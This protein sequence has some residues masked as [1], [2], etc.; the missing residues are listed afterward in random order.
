[1]ALQ[2]LATS[3]SLELSRFLDVK[4][5]VEDNE[6]GRM[7]VPGFTA[8]FS[9]YANTRAYKSEGAGYGVGHQLVVPQLL[10]EIGNFFSKVGEALWEGVVCSVAT[11]KVAANCSEMGVTGDVAACTDAISDWSDSCID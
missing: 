11:A 4:M 8:D 1:L 7:N 3:I 10:D 5:N 6:M 2:R 9:L